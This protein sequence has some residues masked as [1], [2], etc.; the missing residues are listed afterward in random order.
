MLPNEFAAGTRRK[1]RRDA[2][3]AHIVRLTLRVATDTRAILPGDTFV[4]LRGE[5]YDGHDFAREAVARGAAMLIVN[6]RL[7]PKALRTLVVATRCARTWPRCARARRSFPDSRCHHRQYRKNDDARRFSPSCSQTRYGNRVL[8]PPAN[9][10]NEIGVSRLLLQASNEKHD[11]VVVEMGARHYGD[12]AALV[13][14]ARPEVGVLTN[15][16]EAHLEIMGSRERLEETKWAIFAHGARA[17]LNAADEASRRR[18]R[19]SRRSPLVAAGDGERRTMR[20]DGDRDSRARRAN[21]RRGGR[22]VRRPTLT[23]ALPGVHNRANLAAAIAAAAELGVD[24]ATMPPL[25]ALEFPPE[26]GTI[27]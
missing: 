5:R 23:S 22:R 7:R 6:R 17:V 18:A 13:E 10:N 24:L 8:S 21:R 3:R 14:I 26:D 9:E 15:I 12:V 25:P 16:G 20:R 1:R 27:G 2:D 19:R 11:V 4:A